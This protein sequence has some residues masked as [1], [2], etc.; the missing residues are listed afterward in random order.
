ARPRA[1]EPKIARVHGHIAIVLSYLPRGKH[2][3]FGVVF[4]VHE[5]Q[6]LQKI[7]QRQ[8]AL[9]DDKLN[10]LWFE[11]AA[12][13][14]D[15]HASHCVTHMP[16]NDVAPCCMMNKKSRPFERLNDLPC[17]RHRKPRT[18]TAMATLTG[19][20]TGSR[21]SGI[22]RPSFCKLSRYPCMASRAISRVSSIVSP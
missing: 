5:L 3:R 20:T 6:Q 22:S 18:H 9:L 4:L 21:S 2:D 14:R 8:T 16:Q 15:G 10:C 17:G 19:L 1:H 13:R 12:V 11:I 7:L